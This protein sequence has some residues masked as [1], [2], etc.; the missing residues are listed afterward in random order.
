ML[1]RMLTHIGLRFSQKVVSGAGLRL[2]KQF[3]GG[4]CVFSLLNILGLT[5][6][7]I[8]AVVRTKDDTLPC[9]HQVL[10]WQKE[11]KGWT[12]ALRRYKQFFYHSGIL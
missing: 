4:W 9:K 8:L 12:Q 7:T 6:W 2:H 3:K 11:P 10:A 1:R 5:Y